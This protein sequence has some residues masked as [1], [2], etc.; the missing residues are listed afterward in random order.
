MKK[1]F[2]IFLLF[3]FI[4]NVVLAFGSSSINL[5]RNYNSNQNI[6]H[7]KGQLN[8]QKQSDKP[9]PLE[10][11]LIAEEEETETSEESLANIL[12]VKAF[13]LHYFDALSQNKV[14]NGV[15]RDFGKKITNR[16]L[17]TLVENYRI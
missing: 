9:T 13:V 7:Q 6:G 3:I 15:Y 4:G 16:K 5:S 1:F 10:V 8:I 12:F 11:L 17:F 14:G 2:K